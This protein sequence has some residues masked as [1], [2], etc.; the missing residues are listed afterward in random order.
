MAGPPAERESDLA[1]A[2]PG[3]LA[4]GGLYLAY[5]LALFSQF[6]RAGRLPGNCDTWYAVAFTNLYLNAVREL[7]GLGHYGGFLYPSPHPFAYGET[8]VALALLPMLLRACGLGEIASH[9]VFIS[10][11]Y[12]GT[13]LATYLFATLYV[14]SRPAAALAGLAFASSNFLLSTID[15]PHTS[16]FGIAFLSLYFFKRYLLRGHA[17]DLWWA[18]SLAGAQAYFSSYVFLLLAVALAVLGLANLGEL[19]RRGGA[20]LR[21]GAAGGAA[22]LMVAPFFLFYLFRLTDHF[23][24]RS[25]AVLFAE[26]NSLDPQDLANAMPGNL[27][28]PEGHRF[29]HRDA[30]ALQKRLGRSDP[31]FRTEDFALMVGA[32]PREGEESL[33]VSSRRRAF[34]GVLPYLL[35]LAGAWNAFAGRRELLWLFVVGF[36]LALGPLITVGGVMV[37][38]P[39][40]AAYHLVPGAYVFRIPGRAFALALLALDVGAARGIE[41]LQQRCRAGSGPR[42]AALAL[43]LAAAVVV[44]NVPFPM[45][46]FAGAAYVRPPADYE[47]F[48]AAQ[49]G[50]VILN[51]PSGIGYGL[52]GSADDL[53]VFDRELIYMNWQTYHGQSIVNGVNGYIPWSR[54]GV[55]KLTARLPSEEA[56]V[57]L[58][59]LGVGFVAFNKGLVLPGEGPSLAQLRRTPRLEPVLESA[60]TAVFRVR[61]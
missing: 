27:I 23:D 53:Y 44:E 22:A 48:F 50:A 10:A 13:A 39:L 24:W 21:L 52:A 16:F 31:A 14:R 26:F 4:A 37:P 43:L 32:S 8:S 2:F 59:R 25:Q 17:R 36:V 54:I 51:L 3:P 45:R 58:A 18:A 46:S 15:S 30:M 6:P 40:Y 29:D 61:R 55:Q 47:R 1:A 41:R 7:L 56:V 11:V 34:V 20:L 9:Y 12:A 42:A 49:R 38:M 35:A 19:R 57:G 28:Y 5:F 33:W 60:D